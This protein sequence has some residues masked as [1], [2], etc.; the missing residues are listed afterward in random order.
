MQ[1]AQ[2]PAHII[3]YEQ[4]Q[5]RDAD[6]LTATCKRLTLERTSQK[7]WGEAA[8]IRCQGLVPEGLNHISTNRSDCRGDA[9]QQSIVRVGSS[10]EAGD[11]CDIL[12]LQSP[13]SSDGRVDDI[14]PLP[15]ENLD[16]DAS[17]ESVFEDA[18]QTLN[19]SDHRQAFW[20]CCSSQSPI[21][22]SDPAV[23]E[24]VDPIH[25]THGGVGEIM[26]TDSAFLHA[27]VAPW[28]LGRVDILVS[29]TSCIYIVIAQGSTKAFEVAIDEAFP[30]EHRQPCSQWLG[31]RRVVPTL[32]FLRS[33]GIRYSVIRQNIGDAVVIFPGIYCFGVYI[34]KAYAQTSNFVRWRWEPFEAPYSPCIRCNRSASI[35]DVRSAKAS[36]KRDVFSMMVSK[37]NVLI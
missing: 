7:T 3:Q 29:G 27:E 20:H 11:G 1:S 36:G 9:S 19:G 25:A 18:C 14:P 16:H 30:R 32:P 24:K 23:I 21:L 31:H 6:H 35:K 10:G 34:G 2:E 15:L 17:P 4:I 37:T 12:C 5:I 33:R 28:H 22:M 13:N 26:T 8:L